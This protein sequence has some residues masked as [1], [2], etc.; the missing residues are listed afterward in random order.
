MKRYKIIVT[1]TAKADLREAARYITAELISPDASKK[2]M[3]DIKEEIK[4]LATRPFRHAL[5]GDPYLARL[6]IR[7]RYSGNYVVLYIVSEETQTA[8]IAR[9]GYVRRN[10][11]DLL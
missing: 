7:K 9:I 1:K 3:Q 11:K 6:G 10:W 4:K 5:A 2:L 8:A